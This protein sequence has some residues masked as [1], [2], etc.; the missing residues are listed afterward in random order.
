[1]SLVNNKIHVE[2]F[3]LIFEA[4]HLLEMSANTRFASLMIYH[5]YYKKKRMSKY[6]NFYVC[7]ASVL[8]AS[9]LEE[10]QV[11]LKQILCV[12]NYLRHKNSKYTQLTVNE[13]NTMKDKCIIIEMNILKHFGFNIQLE[14]PY[15]LLTSYLKKQNTLPKEPL[16]KN[17]NDLMICPSIIN[18]TAFEICKAAMVIT[19]RELYSKFVC[20]KDLIDLVTEFDS[21]KKLIHDTQ[22]TNIIK[23]KLDAI[24]NF[25]KG[26]FKKQI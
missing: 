15:P 23:P 7:M 14:S 12:F 18:Y 25:V 8:L 21:Y 13:A 2:S 4:I 16:I 20:P 17:L 1:M 3:K 24:K 9:K 26:S 10:Q 22:S 5:K 11:T 19:Y 6:D